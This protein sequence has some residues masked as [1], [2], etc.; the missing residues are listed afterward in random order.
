MLKASNGRLS[1][2]LYYL[3]STFSLPSSTLRFFLVTLAHLNKHKIR[4]V[5]NLNSIYNHNSPLP[6][7]TLHR[8]WGLGRQPLF[9]LLWGRETISISASGSSWGFFYLFCFYCHRLQRQ[10][11]WFSFG[12]KG[13]KWLSSTLF[14]R[15]CIKWSPEKLHNFAKDTFEG[16]RTEIYV[17]F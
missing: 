10:M 8:F 16:S 4:S 2:T 15:K 7:N 1:L 5:S 13:K 6:C 9:Y 17:F 11:A 3:T 12:W 14:F